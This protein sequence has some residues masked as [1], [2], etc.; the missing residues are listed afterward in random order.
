MPSLVQ[1]DQSKESGAFCI[2][3]RPL[4]D[5]P[6]KRGGEHPCMNNASKMSRR[7]DPARLTC[8]ELQ[9][10]DEK[11]IPLRKNILVQ[12]VTCSQGDT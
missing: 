12:G 8:N 6:W 3:C 4:V 5:I 10:P 9:Q 2:D 1:Q 7:I 11:I